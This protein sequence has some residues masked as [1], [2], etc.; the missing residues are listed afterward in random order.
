METMVVGIAALGPSIGIGMLAAAYCNSV[1]RQPEVQGRL[2]P[3]A[4][5]FAGL[6]EV[7]GLLGFVTFVMNKG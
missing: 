6:V 2:F 4:I 3:H 5:L 7:L 1:A